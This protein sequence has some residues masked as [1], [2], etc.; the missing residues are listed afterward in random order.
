VRRYIEQRKCVASRQSVSETEQLQSPM[1]CHSVACGMPTKRSGERSQLR[2]VLQP[3][4]SGSD[5]PPRIAKATSWCTRRS[6]ERQSSLELELDLVLD[7]KYEVIG[8]R[9]A[10]VRGLNKKTKQKDAKT[11]KSQA[12][13]RSRGSNC[14]FFVVFAIFCEFFPVRPSAH[15]S[16]EPDY[17]K[18][19]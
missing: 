14:L 15:L 16:V 3:V 11:S 12:D 17:R 2:E 5:S 19:C 1:H 9:Y 18:A 10:S 7:R 8:Q 6:Q 13:L 4:T